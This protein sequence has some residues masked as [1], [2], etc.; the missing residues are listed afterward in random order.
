MLYLKSCWKKTDLKTFIIKKG[1]KMMWNYLCTII[2]KYHG[3]T[4]LCTGLTQILLLL[5]SSP[6][7]TF[8]RQK[9][10]GYW[11][12]QKL[13]LT[14]NWGKCGFWITE[15][16]F[17]TVGKQLRLH[18]NCWFLWHSIHWKQHITAIL[19]E[20]RFVWVIFLYSF[21]FSLTLNQGAAVMLWSITLK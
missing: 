5:L 12:D 6:T 7:M 10:E 17:N 9:T 8:N 21:A 4:I 18:D 3:F 11:I 19:I 1:L 20:Y 14:W 2:K 13:H 16:Y 15:H